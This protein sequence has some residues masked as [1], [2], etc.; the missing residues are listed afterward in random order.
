MQVKTLVNH[1]TN[2]VFILINGVVETLLDLAAT[3]PTD[4]RIRIEELARNIKKLEQ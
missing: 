4:T 3:E 2:E 1:K